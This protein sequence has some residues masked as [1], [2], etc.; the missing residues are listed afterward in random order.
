MFAFWFSILMF[1]DG[2][3]PAHA[4]GHMWTK[5]FLFFGVGGLRG[6]P[7]PM[8]L[9]LLHF[10]LFL[11]HSSFGDYILME[12]EGQSRCSQII[13]EPSAC[14]STHKQIPGWHRVL[15]NANTP[16]NIGKGHVVYLVVGA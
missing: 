7:S 15:G 4:S 5:Q 6:V 3:P 11:V 13:M 12:G 9:V 2:F 14:V 8:F 1:P 10:K 16:I